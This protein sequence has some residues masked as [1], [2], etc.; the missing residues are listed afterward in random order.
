VAVAEQRF[1]TF[2]HDATVAGAAKT[3]GE[4]MSP[5]AAVVR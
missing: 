2:P 1:I 5:M 4:G 3:E